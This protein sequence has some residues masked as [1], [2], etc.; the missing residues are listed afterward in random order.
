VAQNGLAAESQIADDVQYLVAHEL[1]AESQRLV[2]ENPVGRERDRILERAPSS[3][4]VPAQHLEFLD[5]T[6]CPRRSDLA[7]VIVLRETD[8]A[9]LHADHRMIEIDLARD[10]EVFGRLDRHETVLLAHLDPFEHSQICPRSFEFDHSRFPDQID[11]LPAAAV[12]YRHF[13]RIDLDDGIVHTTSQKRREEM[14]DRRNHDSGFHE[15]RR[16]ADVRNIL[17]RRLDLEIAQIRPP[18]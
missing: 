4:A 3:Q 1:I 11:P 12:E 10:P 13:Q 14:L 8:L 2:I 16:I 6:E 17:R 5:E 7:R 18:E 9:G 15:R